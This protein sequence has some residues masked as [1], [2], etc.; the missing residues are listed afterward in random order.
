MHY[1]VDIS[2][3]LPWTGVKAYIDTRVPNERNEAGFLS[4]A[5]VSA[6]LASLPDC[7]F[8]QNLFR[9]E[10][11]H[12]FCVVAEFTK[13]FNYITHLE[14]GNVIVW[15]YGRDY[16]ERDEGARVAEF[17]ATGELIA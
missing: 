12:N 11:F 14:S 2:F 6:L 1:S 10:K 4:A 7:S 9:F 13:E 17:K 16:A 5:A 3:H 8:F 15:R